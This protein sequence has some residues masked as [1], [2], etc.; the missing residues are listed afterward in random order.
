MKMIMN[1]LHVL[2]FVMSHPSDEMSKWIIFT[3]E[4]WNNYH[5]IYVDIMSD[6]I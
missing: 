4:I 6:I 5:Y 1:V 3:L 2:R